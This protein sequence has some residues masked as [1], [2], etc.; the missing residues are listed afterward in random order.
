MCTVFILLR[1]LL[2]VLIII[3]IIMIILLL[4]LLL[5]TTANG[6][7]SLCISKTIIY[8]KTKLN[9]TISPSATKAKIKLALQC[10]PI[11]F[12]LTFLSFVLMTVHT[13]CLTN[14]L[15]GGVIM[16]HWLTVFFPGCFAVKSKF[17]AITAI[18]TFS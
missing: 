13:G 4:L 2:L 6:Q 1:L 15:G 8:S 11:Y 3:I 5:L 7:T 12:T 17:T 10:L 14:I 16:P 9:I 18:M